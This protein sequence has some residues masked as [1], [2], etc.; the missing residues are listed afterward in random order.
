MEEFKTVFERAIEVWGERSQ[1]EMAQE[2][3]T[4]LALAIR[5]FIRQPNEKRFLDM[6]GEIADVEIMIAQIKM[7][8]PSIEERVEVLKVFKINRLETRLDD[9]RYEE[10]E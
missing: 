5:K 9:L 10:K 6:A 3:S 8:Y 1:L 7:M 2:E 4:E